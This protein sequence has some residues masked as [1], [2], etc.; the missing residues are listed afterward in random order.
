M[1]RFAG[2]EASG[3]WGRS[4]DALVIGSG[5]GGA[6]VAAQLAAAGWSVA[7]LEEGHWHD[8]TSFALDY[9]QASA[10]LYRNH[11]LTTMLGKTATP[12][13]QGKAV[14]GTSVVNGA[15]SW[16]LPRDVFASWL[17]RDPG[18]ARGLDWDALQAA[19]DAVEAR[20]Q[21]RRTDPAVAGP[22]NLLMA[23]G[24]DALGLEHRPIARNVVG[25]QGSGRCLQGCP[26]GAK[27]SMDRT[28]L[29]DAEAH[30][31]DVY[32]GARVERILHDGVRARGVLAAVGP[33][34]WLQ[35]HARHAVVLAAS[36]V[37][38]PL[39]LLR[40]GLGHGP[41][42]RHFMCHPGTSVSGHFGQD[43][44]CWEGATQGHE[45][46][47]LRHEGLKFE[48]LGFDVSVLAAR[49]PGVGRDLHHS[50][51]HMQRDADWG[52]AVKSSAEGRV[53]SVLGRTVVTWSPSAQDLQRARRGVA[54]LGRMLLAAGAERVF[55][56]V[57]GWQQPL[58]RATELDAFERDGPLHATAYQ[59]VATHLFGTCKMGSD[60]ASSVVRPDFAHHT[61]RQLYVADS[62]VF[63]SNTGVNPQTSILAMAALCARHVLGSTQSVGT[64]LAQSSFYGVQTPS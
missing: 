56:G 17:A 11:G 39:L 24:A 6:M 14:G 21:I 3:E 9:A 41:V 42:G 12:Y 26:N 32:S 13:L 34:L 45:V 7:V 52:V 63:P 55:L 28:Y 60:P 4:Y 22:K 18:L 59:M 27:Q 25:C 10:S 50:L 19:T 23:R 44:R 20:L 49:L 47:G 57:A 40:S 5:P 36:A 1:T 51:S 29:R 30:G 54:V 33:D 58:T 8:P 37:G 64:L 53:R 15:I 31:A 62:S 2:A 61:L 35:L 38:S 16:R 43:V 48:A 46:I